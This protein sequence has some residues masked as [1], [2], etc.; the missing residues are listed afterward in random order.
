MNKNRLGTIYIHW[1]QMSS[2]FQADNFGRFETHTEKNMSQMGMEYM[3]MKSWL[4]IRHCTFQV[5]I[6]DKLISR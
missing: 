6:E 1:T 5:R 3:Q 4:Q 2:T